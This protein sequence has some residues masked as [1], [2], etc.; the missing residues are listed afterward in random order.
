MVP[1]TRLLSP[2]LRRV[3]PGT[4]PG[5]RSPC[6]PTARVPCCSPSSRPGWGK[7]GLR[8]SLHRREA[9]GTHRGS[10]KSLVY[11]V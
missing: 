11:S 7:P 8:A 5:Q 2:D 1:K 3:A 6:P 4:P 9:S 10:F